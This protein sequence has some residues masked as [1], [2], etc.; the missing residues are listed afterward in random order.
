MVPLC[1]LRG[2]QERVWEHMVWLAWLCRLWQLQAPREAHHHRAAQRFPVPAGP[3][4]SN[5]SR[6]DSA[7]KPHDSAPKKCWLTMPKWWCSSLSA[8]SWSLELA[9][10]VCLRPLLNQQKICPANPKS[11]HNG[12]ICVYERHAEKRFLSHIPN[13]FLQR[14][15]QP[16]GREQWGKQNNASL[17]QKWS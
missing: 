14:E 15:S 11:F 1:P 7:P 4:R 2:P 6:H 13:V 17:S 10:P 12:G 9:V 5:S 8:P 16:L 3:G